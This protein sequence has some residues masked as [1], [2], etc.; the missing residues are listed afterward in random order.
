MPSDD[1]STAES[2]VPDTP[3]TSRNFRGKKRVRHENKW[4]RS[5]A[6]SKRCAGEEYVSRSK[7]VVP[8]KTFNPCVCGCKRQCNN[9]IPEERQMALHQN[10]YSLQNFD[11]QTAHLFAL[12]KVGN[13]LRTYS[14]NPQSRRNKTRIFLLPDGNGVERQVCKTFFQAVYQVCI[15]LFNYVFF[16][17]YYVFPGVGWENRQTLEEQV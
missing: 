4:I 11:F 9:L 2:S 7:K 6:K 10:F 16:A 1:E 14:G 3:T 17:K 8:A 5:V 12:I 13:K 15:E